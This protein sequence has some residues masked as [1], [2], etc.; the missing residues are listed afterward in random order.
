MDN[1]QRKNS[2]NTPRRSAHP[3]KRTV[4]KKGASSSRRKVWLAVVGAIVAVAALFMW[5]GKRYIARFSPDD[6]AAA[7]VYIPA[8]ATNESVRDS[9]VSALGKDFGGDVASV[10]KGEPAAA[11]GAYKVEPGTRAFRVAR[12]MSRGIQSPVRVSFNNIRT[13]DQLAQRLSRRMEFSTDGFLAACD[14]VAHARGMKA[15]TLVT[16]IFPD[17]YEAFW[18]DTPVKL[19]SRLEAVHTRFWTDSRRDK[20][21]SLGLT[22]ATA[23][24]LASIVEEE[25]AKADERPVIGRLYLNR[26]K[27]GMPLQADPT[28]K[29]ANGDFAARRITGAMLRKDSPYNTYRNK[30]LPPGPIRLVEPATIDG[31]LNSEPHSYIYMCAKADFSG[32]HAFASDYAQHQRN[33]AAY[34]RALDARGIK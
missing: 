22:P 7:W 32:R 4:K 24:I 2:D 29:F 30:G 13:I 26:L 6:G 33:A 34:H 1:T 21:A 28:V 25:S 5:Y 9:L 17:T 3:R 11:H 23:Y 8:G 14:S 27:K 12:N 20:A 10:W 18:T 31:I 16:Y 19:L 15:D